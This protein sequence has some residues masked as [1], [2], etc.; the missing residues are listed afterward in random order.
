MAKKKA[1]RVAK[2]KV[3]KKAKRK[4][5]K[6]RTYQAYTLVKK[7]GGSQLV[8]RWGATKERVERWARRLPHCRVAR[9]EVRE[10]EEK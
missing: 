2:T 3:A 4:P 9:I 8:G 10:I 6:M 1:K 7:S 5:P